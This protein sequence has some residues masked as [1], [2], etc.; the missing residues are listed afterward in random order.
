MTYG[1]MAVEPYGRMS[2]ACTA[3]RPI[4]PIRLSRWRSYGRGNMVEVFDC[5]SVL[6]ARGAHP[7]REVHDDEAVAGLLPQAQR[8]AEL[9]DDRALH[10]GGELA[11]RGADEQHAQ[12]GANGAS[13]CRPRSIEGQGRESITGFDRWAVI[14]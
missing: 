13:E 4:R 6:V 10:A 8:V 12:L 1:R 14:G 3:I 11:R 9:V 2:A 5:A 7:R